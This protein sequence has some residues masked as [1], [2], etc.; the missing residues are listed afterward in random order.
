[1]I[2]APFGATGVRAASRFRRLARVSLRHTMRPHGA[3]VD[4]A[5]DVYKNHPYLLNEALKSIG[6]EP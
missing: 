5:R 6:V 2:A 3:S 4:A 1:M